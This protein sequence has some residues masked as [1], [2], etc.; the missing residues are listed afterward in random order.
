MRRIVRFLC[1]FLLLLC[2][3]AASVAE[4]ASQATQVQGVK[5]HVHTDA[6]TGAAK[7]RLVLDLNGPLTVPEAAVSAAVSVIRGSWAV[8]SEWYDTTKGEDDEVDVYSECSDSDVEEV[9]IE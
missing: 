2:F 8:Q 9:W 1:L 5:S 6:V 4:A 3:S 7:L